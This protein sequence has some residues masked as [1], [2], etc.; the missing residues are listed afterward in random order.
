MP[1]GLGDFFFAPDN[2]L[3]SDREDDDDDFDDL[4]YDVDDAD[5]DKY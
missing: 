1:M 4:D 3:H 5:Q 2:P